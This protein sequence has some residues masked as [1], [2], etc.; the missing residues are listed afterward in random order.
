MEVLERPA[1]V[2]MNPR[3]R[4]L[5]HFEGEES[6]N[7]HSRALERFEAIVGA[8][9]TDLLERARKCIPEGKPPEELEDA[10]TNYHSHLIGQGQAPTSAAQWYSLIRG[11]FSANHIRLGRTPREIMASGAAYESS[12]VLTQK[13][14]RRMVAS[15]RK[16][17]DKLVIAFFA[18]TGQRLGV[19][20][21][22]KYG[23]I[24][25][26]DG[27]GLVEV[28]PTLPNPDGENVNKAEVRYK[29]V[30]GR[31]AMRLIEKVADKKGWV[32]DLSE[33]Q[34]GRI[35]DDAATSTG[36]QES[37]ETKIGRSWHLVHPHV[38]RKYW[39]REMKLGGVK[40][41]DLLNFLMGHKL[42]Y[43]GAYD[44]FTDDDVLKAYKRA[45]PKL[46][47]L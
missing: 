37:L 10:L 22:M 26:V 1:V 34:I 4:W 36:V 21:A 8:K 17:R 12:R 14:V 9:A 40:D 20:T 30:I 27:R 7:R 18:Q 3:E 31:D 19:I 15:R 43:G 32:L 46:R 23:M 28:P 44:S 11:F 24:R 29:F 25:K 45:E 41:P 16:L 6:K 35:F 33:R 42:A 47:V 39:K 38:C 5:S 2:S 13:Q